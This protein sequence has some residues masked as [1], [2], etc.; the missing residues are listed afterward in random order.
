MRSQVL[1]PPGHTPP[2]LRPPVELG[3]PTLG[4]AACKDHSAIPSPRAKGASE[5]SRAERRLGLG[6]GR[7]CCLHGSPAK[8]GIGLDLTRPRPDPTDQ[9]GRRDLEPS[10][11]GPA[12]SPACCPPILSSLQLL[13]PCPSPV[14]VCGSVWVA[15][16][17]GK[18]EGG[19]LWAAWIGQTFFENG[20]SPKGWWS[21][22]QTGAPAGVQGPRGRTLPKG[23]T[24]PGGAGKT[25][26]EGTGRDG[27]ALPFPRG[28]ARPSGR[29][30][31][32]S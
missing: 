19:S 4:G 10:W 5:Q 14:C 7:R 8:R 13:P 27:E 9:E 32:E 26:R 6:L 17:S 15:L 29:L 22:D 25:G 3:P 18:E 16:G 12:V 24:P 11:E 31:P 20:P 21:D 1:D 2:G 28:P 30:F 23:V